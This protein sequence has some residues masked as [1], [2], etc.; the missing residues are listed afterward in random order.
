MRSGK[1]QLAVLVAASLLTTTC[2]ARTDAS[3]SHV[4]NGR[5]TNNEK[6]NN[7]IFWSTSLFTM[8]SGAPMMGPL[9]V[10]V[11]AASS[12]DSSA[13]L[14][15]LRLLDWM[16]PRY[17]WT[18]NETRTPLEHL[19]R[20]NNYLG[21]RNPIICIPRG[22]GKN[23]KYSLFQKGDGS[24][25]DA[26]GIPTRYLLMH[27]NKR[28]L[29]KTSLEATLHWRKQQ[30]IDELLNQ[31]QPKFDLCKAV[32]PHYFLGRDPTGHVIFLQLPA[33]FELDRA[34]KNGLKDDELL[35]HY[36]YV[37]EYLWQVLEKDKPLA[38]MVSV[39]D[40]AGLNLGVLRQGRVTSFVKQMVSTMDAHFPQRAHK[41]LLVNAPKWFNGMYK[42]V[43]P[44]M[45][46]STKQKITILSRG[47]KQDVA[48]REHLGKDAVKNI[49]AFFWSS[50]K[51][52]KGAVDSFTPPPPTQMEQDLRA[53]VLA[54]NKASGVQMQTF[55]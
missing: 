29:A 16:L 4:P 33:K 19:T 38:T 18:D 50:W 10:E 24:E 39:I 23:L 28:H 9:H 37:N 26:D 34:I 35:K 54:R 40:F 43:S 21:F 2:D 45:R 44:L 11:N 8:D 1:R 13:E 55:E 25:T 22:G 51:Q 52:P 31:P 47:V 7:L 27:G 41:T 20:N 14:D 30:K 6:K 48:L 49:P 17:D 15:T 3:K 5:A 46:E 32:F 36:I 42:L 53:F 12:G